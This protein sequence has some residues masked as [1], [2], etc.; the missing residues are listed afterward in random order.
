MNTMPGFTAE[1]V[2][3]QSR[4]TYRWINVDDRLTVV[5]TIVPQLPT[6]RV[7][8][9]CSS[10]FYGSHTCCDIEIVSCSPTLKNCV[11]NFNNCQSENCGLLAPILGV[12]F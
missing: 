10:F 9:D 3:Y 7:C 12:F 11:V 4:L 1:N 5:N 8:N 6:S 2:A